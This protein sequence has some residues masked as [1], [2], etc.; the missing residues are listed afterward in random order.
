MILYERAHLCRKIRYLIEV[1]IT[2]VFSLVKI[3]SDTYLQ[4]VGAREFRTASLPE[5][6]FI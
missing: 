4:S 6:R 5:Q 2:H 3:D 1:T